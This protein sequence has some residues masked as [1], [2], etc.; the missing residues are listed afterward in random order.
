MLEEYP[1]M[2]Q[3]SDESLRFLSSFEGQVQSEYTSI[4]RR[5]TRGIVKSVV[6]LII[7][8]FLVGI[9][10]EVPYDIAVH[11]AVLWTPL[12]FNLFSTSVYG[13]ASYYSGI[14]GSCKYEAP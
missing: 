12:L 10:I 9:A 6:F 4:S 5:V 13:I 2:P 14:T 8:K 3:L 7:T 1:D 11:G